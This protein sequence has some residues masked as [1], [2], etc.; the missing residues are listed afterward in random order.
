MTGWGVERGRVVGAILAS[1]IDLKQGPIGC[2][3]EAAN[4]T[5]EIKLTQERQVSLLVRVRTRFSDRGKLLQEQEQSNI[6]ED[7]ME[8]SC[9]DTEAVRSES[10]V[11]CPRTS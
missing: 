10:I 2:R 1:I 5:R 4:L 7:D 9:V 11:G 8:I 6:H 3:S